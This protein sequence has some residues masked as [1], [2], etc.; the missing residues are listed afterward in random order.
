MGNTLDINKPGYIP[1]PWELI[2]R[3][4]NVLSVWALKY[5]TSENT[6]LLVDHT[7]SPDLHHALIEL[8]RLAQHVN[9]NRDI[10]DIQKYKDL[11]KTRGETII[12][13]SDKI[14]E[15]LHIINICKGE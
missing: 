8:R 1:E 5:D 13:L 7:V 12:K 10:D 15:G 2:S 11:A 14:R 3:V 4:R 9:P 6:N